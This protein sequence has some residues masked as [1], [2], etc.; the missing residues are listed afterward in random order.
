MF[1]GG[2][3]ELTADDVKYSFERIADP[4]SK[5]PYKDDWAALDHVEVK[6]HYSGTIVLKEPFA[7]LWTSA[8]ARPRAAIIC[9]RR[10]SR[11]AAN[12]RPS[13]RPPPGPI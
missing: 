10:S 11:R 9:K 7:P 12:S 1:T 2:F 13:R 8:A 6:D 3:G 5:S 4:Q